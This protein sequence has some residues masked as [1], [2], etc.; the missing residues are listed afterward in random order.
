GDCEG[1][2]Q[3]RTQ[4]SQM[5]DRLM[6]VR[7]AVLLALVMFLS[8]CAVAQFSDLAVTDDGSQL[9]F[10]TRL[11]MV[12]ELSLDLPASGAIY[13]IQAGKLTRVTDPPAW[14]IDCSIGYDCPSQGNPQI[15]GD[16]TVFS[17]T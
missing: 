12:S 8:R 9:Y 3:I 11:S 13:R 6:P 10:A 1:Y 15:S 14:T 17:Y 5:M 7:A 2:T 4:V 16:G